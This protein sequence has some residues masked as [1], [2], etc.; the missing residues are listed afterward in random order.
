MLLSVSLKYFFIGLS[1]NPGKSSFATPYDSQ[2]GI[3]E[4]VATIVVV[5]AVLLFLYIGIRVWI[6]L[7]NPNHKTNKRKKRKS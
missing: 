2:T 5:F 4:N 1:P 7:K 6:A 3:P